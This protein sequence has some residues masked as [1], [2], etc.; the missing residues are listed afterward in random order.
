MKNNDTEIRVCKN[1]QCQR[2][3]PVGYK[4]RFCE[5][6]RNQQVQTAKNIGKGIAAVAGTIVS[7]AIVIVTKG[8]INP[9]E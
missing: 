9:K 4:H 5:S 8:K 2:V 3:L 6:C 7:V 1:K